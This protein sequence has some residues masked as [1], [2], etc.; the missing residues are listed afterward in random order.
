MLQACIAEHAKLKMETA[1]HK[2]Q[3]SLLRIQADEDAKRAA[4]EHEMTRREVDALRVT[5]QSQ[6]ARREVSTASDSTQARYLQLQYAYEN[7]LADKEALRKKLKGAKKLIQETKEDNVALKE[8]RELLTTRI[9]ENRE[10]FNQ[11][12]SPG[13]MFYGISTPKTQQSSPAQH[14]STP[15]Q[16]PRSA[17]RDQDRVERNRG[18]P[19]DILAQVANREEYG[20]AEPSTPNSRF[21]AAKHTRGAQSMS[22]LPTTPI[23]KWPQSKHAGLLPSMEV[24]PQTEPPNRHSSRTFVPDTPDR[25]RTRGRSRDS[26]ISAEDERERKEAEYE[27]QR[28]VALQALAFESVSAA[29]N[30]TTSSMRTSGSGR[31]NRPQEE[32]EVYESQASQKATE[33][34]RH[35]P[36]QSF[37]VASSNN[38]RDVTPTPVAIEKSA[39]LQSKLFAPHTKS[40][41]AHE[42]RKFSGPERDDRLD[43]PT[44]RLRLAG[45]LREDGSHVGLGIH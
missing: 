29:H 16:T 25:D 38:S 24:V 1:H 8:E 3:Y 13:G 33:L 27:Q 32:E 45:G 6:Q 40:G 43:S 20:H 23:G 37:D 21:K 18:Q 15:K 12:R 41:L 9:R 17:I 14:R 26:T 34:L 30:T 5:E 19:L 31:H 2:L 4:V 22:S 39:K 10:H 28:Q 36:R 42:K 44:K 35:D 11:L 7:V